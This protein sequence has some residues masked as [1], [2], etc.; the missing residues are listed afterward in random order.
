MKAHT[1]GCLLLALAAHAGAAQRAIDVALSD[2]KAGRYER[3]ELT[4]KAKP[5]F[6]NP[7]D[8]ADVDLSLEVT[9]PSG[10]RLTV[11]AF[12]YQP[13]E[14]KDIGQG[15][16]KEAWLYPVGEP[17]WKV[18]FA[19]MEVG[20]HTCVARLKDRM[21]TAQSATLAFECVP[22]KSKGY[23]RVSQRDPRFLEF[24]E[25][26][27]FFAVGQNIAF[28]KSLPT[29]EAMLAKLGASG[30]NYARVWTCCEDWGMAI[31]ARKSAW[32]RSWA[33][34]P[35]IVHL[36]GRNGY[37]TDGKCILVASD[38]RASVAVSP[39][40]KV[41]LRPSTKYV[42]SGLVQTDK[43]GG[44][45]I[46]ISGTKPGEP[47]AGKR[48]WARFKREL[49]AT[50][51]QW[52]MPHISLRPTGKGRAWV[53]HLSLKEAGGGPELLWEADVR[54]PPR[55]RYNQLDCFILDKV[56]EAAERSGVYLQLC[57]LTRDH[58]MHALR[59]PRS[60]EYDAAVADANKLL[61]Y[62]VA[63]WGCSTHVATWEYFNEMNPGLPTDRF[64]AECG[65]HLE[66]IDPYHHLRATSAWGPSAKDRRHPKLDVADEHFY[67]RPCLKEKF[68]DG[69]GT[70]LE[71]VRLLRQHAPGKPAL[72][73]EFGM[74]AD[75]WQKTDYM[76]KDTEFAHLHNALWASALSG[77]SGTVMHWFW[78]DIHTRD[79]YRHYRPI[80]A[81]VA[82]IP[83]TT[84]KLREANARA[85]DPT[86]RIVGLQG[87]HR[88]YLWVFNPQATWWKLAVD[89]ANP[90]TVAGAT[91][92]LKGLVPG[93]YRVEWWDTWQGR[94]TKADTVR[95]DGQ[96][97]KL[98]V[99]AFAR[100]V[101]CKITRSER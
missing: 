25:G 42:L 37:H 84:A 46:Q 41:A 91:I 17:V 94:A 100:D 26:Q 58:Y 101:A 18:R 24:S 54:R 85:S 83:F 69:V 72:L 13:F 44:L 95:A 82:D 9:T 76:D 23:V 21:G 73:S 99:P 63:R 20:K 80:S 89:R 14:R 81:F 62:A 36:P 53:R 28:I 27:P 11:P 16:R 51:K 35:P 70:V 67:L 8:P 15:T 48:K 60:P 31:E 30:G 34:T 86:L 45:A 66:R 52:W 1:A 77:L 5:V 12:Y 78:D 92:E 65:E 6:S 7:C 56:V 29:A 38:E 96:M 22:S 59:D 79:L 75:N 98:R 39:S 40:H 68:R 88:A 4:L 19:P 43:D 33:W 10:K 57:L 93:G 55:G 47:I 32:G 2:S 71:R 87:T 3:L 49:T 74:T 50:D 61:R 64:Y 90:T 97:L